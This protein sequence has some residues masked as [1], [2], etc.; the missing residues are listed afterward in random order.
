[1]KVVNTGH[2]ERSDRAARRSVS[3]LHQ[4]RAVDHRPLVGQRSGIERQAVIS[5]ISLERGRRGK[6]N[7]QRRPC[8]HR[9]RLIRRRRRRRSGRWRRRR[10]RVNRDGELG[11]T[12]KNAVRR[13]QL[14]LVVALDWKGGSST[15]RGRVCKIH[16]SRID[17]ERLIRNGPLKGQ[18]SWWQRQAVICGI[19]GQN[20]GVRQMDE[21]RSAHIDAGGAVLVA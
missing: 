10:V 1:M 20:S 15:S 5:G 17:S 19:P 2:R 6:S 13:A 4:A 21:L 11:L 9:W 16:H 3:E 18:R 7:G 8:I 14:Q 12:G